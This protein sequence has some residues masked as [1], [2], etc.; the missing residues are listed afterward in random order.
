ML[1]NRIEWYLLCQSWRTV[2]IKWLKLLFEESWRYKGHI[3][4]D[5]SIKSLT[6]T[7]WF[8]FLLPHVYNVGELQYGGKN[9]NSRCFLSLIVYKHSVVGSSLLLLHYFFSN[10]TFCM[11]TSKNQNICCKKEAIHDK[12]HRKYEVDYFI[13]LHLYL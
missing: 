9:K 13:S 6:F 7:F 3:K 4:R 1:C 8:F 5:F 2:R 10:F 11:Y 12:C